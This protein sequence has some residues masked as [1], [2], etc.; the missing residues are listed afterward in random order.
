MQT[1]LPAAA[2]AAPRLPALADLGFVRQALPLAGGEAAAQKQLGDFLP[3]LGQ[4]HLKRDFSAQKSTSQLSVYLRFGLLS[5]R[6]L[7]QLAR[8][9]DNEGAAAWLNELVWREFYQQFLYHHPNVVQESWRPEYR[10][11]PWPD[12]PEYLARWQA[13]QTG[14]P[15]IDAA[16][17]QLKLSGQMHNRLRMLCAG[18]LS[19]D[20]LIDWR[21]GEAWFAAQLLDFDLAANNGGWQW[22]AGTGCDAQPYFRIFNP[23]IQSQKYDPDGTFIRRHVPELAHLG[24]EVI[25]APWLAKHDID[26]HGY[27]APIVNHVLQREKALA[28][29]RAV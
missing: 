4:Y 12:Q 23:V 3:Q 18:F 9:A 11:L 14:Y 24:K 15:I 2:R 16:M 27:P 22:A 5:I 10:A 17:R 6:H 21:L 8:Q 1:Q 26:T 20:L 25:H 19:K 29:Y 28:F 13:G 7:V